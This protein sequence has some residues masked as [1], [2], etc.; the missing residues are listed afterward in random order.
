M[1]AAS[2]WKHHACLGRLDRVTEQEPGV[3]M[4]IS[5]HPDKQTQAHGPVLVEKLHLQIVF[6]PTAKPSFF[7]SFQI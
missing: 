7:V 5:S 4:T 6:S 1:S 2:A 3:T